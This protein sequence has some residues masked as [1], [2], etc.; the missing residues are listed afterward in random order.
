[1]NFKETSSKV[2]GPKGETRGHQVCTG[3]GD[4][5]TGTRLWRDPLG[6]QSATHQNAAGLRVSK[7]KFP[8]KKTVI[9]V[10]KQWT[11]RRAPTATSARTS[12]TAPCTERGVCKHPG[13]QVCEI[14]PPP[15]YH[16]SGT[17][18]TAHNAPRDPSVSHTT[19]SGGGTGAN[20][21]APLR[22]RQ[23]AAT[24]VQRT[25]AYSPSRCMLVGTTAGTGLSPVHH[26]HNSSPP[27]LPPR[28]SLWGMT[29]RPVNSAALPSE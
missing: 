21:S 20:G 1:M 11:M 29:L 14:P 13:P 26:Y 28:C 10:A 19:N 2:V 23:A 6:V 3:V 24:P 4:G 5:G 17:D 18:S 22:A 9:W 15:P 27:F 12:V 7:D 16:G 25:T 8:Q